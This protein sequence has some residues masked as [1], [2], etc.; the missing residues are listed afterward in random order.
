MRTG[1]LRGRRSADPAGMDTIAHQQRAALALSQGLVYIAY[2]GL[3]GDCADYHGWVVASRTDGRGP[4]LSY[5]VPTTREGGIWAASGP[6]V[7]SAGNIYVA[8]G[9]GAATSGDWDHSD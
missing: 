7:D 8:V 1:Q 5:Q 6:A 3:D 4:L 2:G 9:N